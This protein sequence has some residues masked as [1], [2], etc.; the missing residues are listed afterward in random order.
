[1][2]STN[3]FYGENHTWVI[4]S[5]GARYIYGHVNYRYDKVSYEVAEI[6]G[7]SIAYCNTLKEAI[8]AFNKTE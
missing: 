5:E 3:D 8:E 4:A 6:G 2:I 7:K 1:M